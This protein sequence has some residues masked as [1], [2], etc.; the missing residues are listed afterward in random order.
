[1]SSVLEAEAF[2]RKMLTDPVFGGR[3][4]VRA[5]VRSAKGY[6]LTRTD[7]REARKRLG[8]ISEKNENGSQIWRWPADA[9]K[10]H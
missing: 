5:L 1:M 2:I 7:L 3:M 10:G 9:G 8:V 4:E 6:R